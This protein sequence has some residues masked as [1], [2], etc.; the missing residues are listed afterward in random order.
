MLILHCFPGNLGS[1][2]APSPTQPTGTK[3]QPSWT[4]EYVQ[5]SLATA[6]G[7]P[8]G[9]P[10]WRKASLQPLLG[11]DRQTESQEEKGEDG[12]LWLPP[13][14]TPILSVALSVSCREA[15][16]NPDA[17]CPAEG[18][19]LTTLNLHHFQVWVGCSG[20]SKGHLLPR[21]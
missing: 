9:D 18:G 16:L 19:L 21:A 14:P 1:L 4:V 8:E 10:E 3:K 13:S 6:L 2:Y 17:Y 15:E 5:D 12:L 20:K 11:T 7:S